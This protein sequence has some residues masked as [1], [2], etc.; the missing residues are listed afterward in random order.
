MNTTNKE[1]SGYKTAFKSTAVFGGVQICTILLN[2][3]KTKVVALL[4]GTVGFGIISIY[5]TITNLIHTTTNL[6]LQSSAVRD[7]SIAYTENNQDVLAGKHKAIMRW[8]Y[9]CS[10]GGA[11]LTFL[12]ANQLSIAFFENVDYV[13]DIRLLSI[14][15][16]CMGVY[17]ANYAYLQGIRKIKDMANATVY[18]AVATLLLSLPLYYFYK[19]DGIVWS[20]IIGAVATMIIGCFYT[21]KH[22]LPAIRQ[23][24]RESYKLGRGTIQ[25][26]I[27]MSIGSISVLLVQF[28]IKTFIARHG[29]VS[30]VGLYQAGWAINASYLGMVFT[31]I[32]KDYF[33]RLSSVYQ[34]NSKLSVMVNEQSEI[35]VLILAP[36]IVCMVVFIE[37]IIRI[38][39]SADFLSIIEMTKWLLIGSIIKAGSFGI[40]YIFL[41]KGDKKMYLFN[42]LGVKLITIPSYL[43]GYKI[44]GLSGIGYAYT[45]VYCVFFLWVSLVSWLRYRIKYNSKYWRLFIIELLLLLLYPLSQEIFGQSYIISVIIMVAILLFSFYEFQKRIDIISVIKRVFYGKK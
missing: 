31:A 15:V 11:L 6:G 24:W 30:D 34:D 7:L 14:V 41:A 45:F 37:P 19:I 8:V 39:Y 44:W 27:A 42:E 40:S 32:A 33:P 35:S 2:V 36:L 18:G 22:K 23:S 5:N 38:L 20:L 21:A 29:G 17:N 12:F 28:I 4:M 26:G 43:L 9:V 25:L 3:I 1:T 10:V 13:R 16:F